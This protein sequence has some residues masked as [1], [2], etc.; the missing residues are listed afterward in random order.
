M[1]K[2]RKYVIGI[3]ALEAKARS[4]PMRNI[5]QRLLDSH[6]FE[7]IMFGDKV[8]IDEPVG[9]WPSCDLLISF[10][11]TGFPLQKAIEY[12]NLRGPYCVNDLVMQKL[13]WDRRL[14]LLLLDTIGVRTPRRLIV[15]RDGGP[16]L[17]QD[18]RLKLHSLGV[19]LPLASVDPV[20]GSGVVDA[21]LCANVTELDIDTIQVGDRTL[22]KPFVEKPVNGENHNIWIYYHS[23]DG[24]GVRKLFRKVA[25]KA[26]EYD[27]N[28]HSVRTEGSYIYEVFMDVDNAEDVKVYTVG[29][30]YIHAETRKSPVV[31]GIVR[32]NVDGKEIRF[33]TPLTPDELE[34]A[35]RISKNF[36]QTVCGLD[37]LRVSGESY[38]I[39]VNGWS[40]VKGNQ[41]YYDLCA[42]NLR[43]YF[44]AD[45]KASLSR[46]SS[47][48]HSQIPEAPLEN[49][50]RL[51]S[52]I[53]VFRHAD[54]TPKQKLK[55][56]ATCKPFI[57]LLNGQVDEI[58]L[59]KKDLDLVRKAAVE[60]LDFDL[61]DRAKMK[62]LA[63]LLDRKSTELGTKVQIKPYFS[64]VD[65]MLEKL[66]IVVKWGGEFTHAG[67]F[68][69]KD[70]GE[71]LRKDLMIVNKEVF[72]DVK[73]YTS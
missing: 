63:I 18:V 12:V 53:S 11:S 24:G 73:V 22:T 50:W 28:V 35:R 60:A 48:V 16:V 43:K 46:P 1:E 58:T 20:D 47:T 39:D 38:V 4:K 19:S 2:D 70:L 17:S 41:N 3:C 21:G 37:L 51:K 32:R 68:H 44:L 9:A 10:F 27:P 61:E 36:M 45:V 13:L 30:D 29:S 33:V 65:G 72:D 67:V 5:L 8:I 57:A 66:Q 64:K 7:T 34:M 62:H 23:R 6:E 31:D 26:S 14:V 25:N 69:S 40:F 49:Q 42:L 15:S 59:K 56:Y 54:R 71:N 52:Y 55:F